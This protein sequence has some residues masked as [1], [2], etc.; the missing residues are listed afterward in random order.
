MVISRLI[1][2]I[3]IIYGQTSAAEVFEL[4]KSGRPHPS[5][6]E[7][8][9]RLAAGDTVRFSDGTSYSIDGDVIRTK[10]TVI[11]PVDSSRIL[12]VA[13]GDQE[14]PQEYLTSYH[15]GYAPLMYDGIVVPHPYGKTFEYI[16]QERI[17]VKFL[18]RDLIG[19]VE[20]GR[21]RVGDEPLLWDGLR[22]F[23][24]STHRYSEI[25]DFNSG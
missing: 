17:A 16:Y 12:R 22:E 2:V 3:L 10:Y 14:E 21:R 19:D 9:E 23:L 1:F 11:L 18:L 4:Y 20:K 15:Q 5:Y 25:G 8:V 7:I 24:L 13:R 6:N